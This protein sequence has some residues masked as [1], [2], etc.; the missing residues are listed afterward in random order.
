MATGMCPMVEASRG[1][2]AGPRAL[3][4]GSGESLRA[5]ALQA[6]P[7]HCRE[8][9]SPARW[10]DAS[11]RVCPEGHPRVQRPLLKAQGTPSTPWWRL[12]LRPPPSGQGHCPQGAAEGPCWT[13]AHNGADATDLGGRLAQ[14]TRAAGRPVGS[15]PWVPRASLSHV[16]AP[17]AALLPPWGHPASHRSGSPTRGRMSPHPLGGPESGTA[18]PSPEPPLGVPGRVAEPLQSCSASVRAQHF[19][20]ETPRS[21]TRRG[22]GG[23]GP[24]GGLA[25]QCVQGLVHQARE[26]PLGYTDRRGTGRKD[27]SRD[28]RRDLKFLSTHCVPGTPKDPTPWASDELEDWALGGEA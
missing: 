8:W 18:R 19:P 25:L 24:G 21:R 14:D 3:P 16:P 17:A 7:P 2:R 6:R 23:R 13:G 28:Y 27:G 12:H 15:E 4:R 9:A 22:P 26:S 11:P 5:S 1:V 20:R 10:S